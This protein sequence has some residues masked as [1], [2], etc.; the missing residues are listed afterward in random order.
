MGKCSLVYKEL[1]SEDGSDGSH[2]LVTHWMPLPE[3][4]K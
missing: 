1:R 2:W 4:P 3:A